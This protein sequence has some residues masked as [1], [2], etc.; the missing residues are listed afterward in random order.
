MEPQMQQRSLSVLGAAILIAASVACQKSES[1]TPIVPTA[2]TATPAGGATLKSSAP[3]PQSPV[4]DIR[5]ETFSIPTLTAGPSTPTNGGTGVA[6]QYR[7]QLLNEAGGVLE[8][9]SLRSTSSWTPSVNLDFDKRYRWQVRAEFDGAVSAWSTPASFLSPNGGFIRGSQVFDPLTNGRTVGSMVG[10]HFVTGPNGGWEADTRGDGLQYDIPTC[11]SCKVEFDVTNFG[12]GEGMS[13]QVDV[14]WFS[15]GD[16]T[17]WGGFTPFRDHPWKMH[18]EQRSDGDGTGM[19]VIWRNGAADADTD[20]DPEYGDHRGKFLDGGPNF[21]HSF[22]NKVWHFVIE[23]TIGTY[24]ISIGENGG[25]PKQWFPGPGG[26]SGYFNGGHPYAPPNHRIELGCTPRYE[27]MI[28][29]R[30]RNF[31]ITPQ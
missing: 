3:T 19:Q 22:D 8:E 21:G 9:S 1:L 4:N 11:A 2:V 5:L 25:T 12:G 7:F 10:G 18:L 17:A 29:A 23:W 14:K 28:G 6:V 15:M 13:A 16:R 20:G 27:S 31:K 26:D 24:K 30:Y